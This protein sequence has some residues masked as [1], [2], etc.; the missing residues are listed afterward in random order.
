MPVTTVK[1]SAD[2]QSNLWRI[3]LIVIFI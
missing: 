2:F 1:A 3:T